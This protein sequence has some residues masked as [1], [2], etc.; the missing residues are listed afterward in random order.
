MPA[1]IPI[2][3]LRQLSPAAAKIYLTF[4]TQ[5]D[6][7]VFSISLPIRTLARQ[8]GYS[9]R[10]CTLALRQLRTLNLLVPH[11]RRY[12]APTAYMVGAP[13]TKDQFDQTQAQSAPVVA[14]PIAPVNPENPPSC[15]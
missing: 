8:T 7:S 2:H 15:P 4:I 3:I 13:P 1:L 12:H 9:P 6:Q 10:S 11:P 5:T 14:Q